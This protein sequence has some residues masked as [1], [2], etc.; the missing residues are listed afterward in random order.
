MATAKTAKTNA[1]AAP[2]QPE[3]G[4]ASAAGGDHAR[5]A[6]IRTLTIARQ[7]PE[8]PADAEL[9]AIGYA[10]GSIERFMAGE[11]DRRVMRVVG[12]S[13]GFA[14]QAVAAD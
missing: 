12:F 10:E 11:D 3:A 7:L 1:A 14:A 4:H 5:T 6:D 8:V 9:E 2:T 13:G